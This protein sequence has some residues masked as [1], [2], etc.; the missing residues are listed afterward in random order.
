M[1]PRLQMVSD[2]YPTSCARTGGATPGAINRSIHGKASLAT[3]NFIRSA[4]R[5]RGIIH[6]VELKIQ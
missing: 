5:L 2:Q 4:S 6:L 1:V 3:G